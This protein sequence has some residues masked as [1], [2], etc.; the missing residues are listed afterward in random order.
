MSEKNSNEPLYTQESSKINPAIVA[1]ATALA[2]TGICND[3]NADAQSLLREVVKN[4]GYGF[5]TPANPKRPIA[6]TNQRE[7][8]LK[9]RQVATFD[10]ETLTSSLREKIEEHS[11]GFGLNSRSKITEPQVSGTIRKG[12]RLSIG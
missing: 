7:Q 1:L 4:A 10:P 9:S 12:V 5:N 6:P 2:T 8:F 3:V 11:F